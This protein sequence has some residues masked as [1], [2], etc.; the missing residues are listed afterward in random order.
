MQVLVIA[1]S[2]PM[3]DRS[4]EE[5]RLSEMLRILASRHNVTL[6]VW[7]LW[8]QNIS[9]AEQ[10]RYVQ[11]LES[12]GIAL[13]E[14]YPRRVLKE[15]PYDVVFIEWYHSLEVIGEDIRAWQPQAKI[16]IDAVD[17][18]YRRVQMEAQLGG[19]PRDRARA[20]KI[21]RRE[22]AAY[23]KAD[24]VVTVSEEEQDILLKEN[25]KLFTA[26]VPNIHR[27][28]EQLSPLAKEP[29]LVF[30]GS[31]THAPNVDG[32]RFFCTEVFPLVRRQVPD[33][34]LLIVGNAPTDVICSLRSE[35][36]TVTGYVSDIAAYMR[37]ARVSVVPLRFGAGMKGKVGESIC[38]GV[39]VVTTQVGRQGMELQHDVDVLVADDP[40]SFACE[41]TRLLHDLQLCE[42]LREAAFAKLKDTLGVKRAE[43]RL[44][45]MLARL[46]D[47]SATRKATAVHRF[48]R[49]SIDWLERHL[50]W[51]F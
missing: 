9:E 48:R 17:L 1:S 33:V 12:L 34:H 37:R 38:H 23:G 11:N 45:N 22:L 14:G 44:E 26:V 31:F 24:I 6:C 28:P 43:E 16:V 21:Q 36:I 5:L 10:R 50:L 13:R 18:E 47:S 25:P 4:S 30:V 42:R 15:R 39:P 49:K 8:S 41:V 32:V 29:V 51:R 35:S 3:P 2:I 20:G 40:K 46:A 19:S 7:S 27:F